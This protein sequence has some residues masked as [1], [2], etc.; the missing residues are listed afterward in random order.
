MTVAT[1]TYELAVRAYAKDLYRYAYWLCRN[2][3]QADDLVQDALLRAWKH[4]HRLEDAQAVK[5]WL[6]RIVRREFLRQLTRTQRQA[7]DQLDDDMLQAASDGSADMADTLAIRQLLL[8]APASLREPLVLQVLGGFSSAEIAGLLGTR[9]G[10][11]M[12]RLTRARQWLRRAFGADAQ[13]E[14][15]A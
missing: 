10:A 4:W 15:S 12:T 3:S 2:G 14:R 1:R 5:A 7:M 13:E 11:V 8:Q 6:F 9:D